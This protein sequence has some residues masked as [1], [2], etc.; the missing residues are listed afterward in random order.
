VV[1]Y[2]AG[3]VST[4]VFTAEPY[5]PHYTP[6]PSPEP[7]PCHPPPPPLP[8]PQPCV[9]HLVHSHV[10]AVTGLLHFVHI[11]LSCS[12]SGVAPLRLGGLVQLEL[13]F[14]TG[15]LQGTCCCAAR[16]EDLGQTQQVA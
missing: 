2:G 13:D 16:L 7:Y 12:S 5:S 4:E 14:G 3:N 10:H 6:T 9:A 15:Q 11:P 8:P 1:S